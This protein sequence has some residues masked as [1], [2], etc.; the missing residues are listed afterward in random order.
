[1][2]AVET[3]QAHLRSWLSLVTLLDTTQVICV[4][5]IPETLF[6]QCA[7]FLL[8][9]VQLNFKQ[10]MR[11]VPATSFAMQQYEKDLVRIDKLCEEYQVPLVHKEFNIGVRA[12]VEQT[13]GQ[14]TPEVTA[15]ERELLIWFHKFCGVSKKPEAGAVSE[16]G[17]GGDEKESEQAARSIKKGAGSKQGG[18]QPHR[19]PKDGE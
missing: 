7:R 16:G 6:Q 12:L 1:M 11:T 2:K 4:E 5:V 3:R 19:T 8:A 13:V 10:Q 14:L 18:K 17:G 15:E 9:R